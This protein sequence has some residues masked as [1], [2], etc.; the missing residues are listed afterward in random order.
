MMHYTVSTAARQKTNFSIHASHPSAVFQTKSHQRD[1]TVL[2]TYVIHAHRHQHI[3]QGILMPLQPSSKVYLIYSWSQLPFTHKSFYCAGRSRT[4]LV[5]STAVL[6]YGKIVSCRRFLRGCLCWHGHALTGERGE[7]QWPCSTKWLGAD[8]TAWPE[9]W[10]E[11]FQTHQTT[12]GQA[13]T[14]TNIPNVENLL[15][16]LRR[17]KKREKKRRKQKDI[18]HIKNQRKKDWE[19]GRQRQRDRD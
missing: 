19:R 4:W 2:H 14:T 6:I 7:K 12:S 18:I 11:K 3:C 15:P 1:G 17:R 10:L 13:T 8:K 9:S 5:P 16:N